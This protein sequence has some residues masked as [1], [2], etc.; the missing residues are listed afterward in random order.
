[1]SGS[2][3]DAR[4]SW[5]SRTQDPRERRRGQRFRIK[6]EVEVT[7]ASI[8]SQDDFRVFTTVDLSESGALLVT[9]QGPHPFTQSS[10]LNVSFSLPDGSPKIVC[11]AKQ[12][13]V[14]DGGK[15]GIRFVQIE[16]SDLA[17]LRRFL[18]DLAERQPELK[19]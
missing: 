12:A 11:L 9:R 18:S 4:R 14:G 17:T 19:C 2:T 6:L 7:I 5:S 15:I 1:M 3:P 10:I 13:R 16:D 8:G